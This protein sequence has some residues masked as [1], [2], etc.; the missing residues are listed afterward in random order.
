MN[1]FNS[2]SSAI[3]N[4]KKTRAV[5]ASSNPTLTPSFPY[6]YTTSRQTTIA[7][8]VKGQYVSYCCNDSIYTSQNY[9]VIFNFKSIS[10]TPFTS[11]AINTSGQY[12]MASSTGTSSAES[13]IY[14]SS[15]YGVTWTKRMSGTLNN[16]TRYFEKSIISSSGLY[17]FCCSTGN[18]GFSNAFSNDY[19][20]T[21]SFKHDSL[22]RTT[23]CL[24]GT[25]VLLFESY[26]IQMRRIDL[27]N[28]NTEVTTTS[29]PYGG[30]TYHLS[31]D[32]VGNV[33]MIHSNHP[34]MQVST[35]FGITWINRQGLPMSPKF[36]YISGGKIWATSS[37]VF[38]RSDDLGI[39]FTLIYTLPAGE[40]IKSF[41]GNI[42]YINFVCVSGKVGV[43]T[44]S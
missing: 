18:A 34:S 43:L 15:D 20:A 23:G 14:G 19:G 30:G 12:Q 16:T 5:V 33:V 1:T 10:N 6:A 7:C 41:C 37:N 4:S 3:L 21:F 32:N 28:P 31:S 38:Y 40:T 42:T 44:L 24:S 39:T 35:D 36:A 13:C 8:S 25:N 27:L 9:G 11:I 29:S 26:N 17:W 22:C 2:I